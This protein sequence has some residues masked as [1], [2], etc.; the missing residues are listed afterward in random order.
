MAEGLK[1]NV[2]SPRNQIVWCKIFEDAW[3]DHVFMLTAS[4]QVVLLKTELACFR[5][6]D[7][8]NFVINTAGGQTLKPLFEKKSDR[9]R[10]SWHGALGQNALCV[11]RRPASS[12]DVFL[13]LC[14]AAWH[15]RTSA[16]SPGAGWT[17]LA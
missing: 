12:T 7:W 2:M 3:H 14:P 10:V 6:A 1:I 5:V 8:R 9:R 17:A 15:S 11:C 16:T 4:G 13:C